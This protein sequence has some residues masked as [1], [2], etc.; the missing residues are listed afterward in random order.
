MSIDPNEARGGIGRRRR[1]PSAVPSLD[2]RVNNFIAE[3]IDVEQVGE[4]NLEDE[5]SVPSE[6]QERHQQRGREDRLRRRQEEADRRERGSRSG[7]ER[8]SYDA[9]PRSRSR[10][11]RRSNSTRPVQ[12][13]TDPAPPV[14]RNVP[15]PSPPPT[16][17]PPEKN[18]PRK[19]LVSKEE[20]RNLA[21]WLN[22]SVTPAELKGFSE[23]YPIEFEKKE[24]SLAPPR[25]DDW[26]AR[27]LK[28]S[29]AQKPAEAA[30]KTWLSV[31]IKVLD[32]AGPLVYLHQLTKQGRPL[33]MEDVSENVK[34]ALELTAAASYDI[35]RRRRRNILSHTNPRSDYLLEDPKSF[36]SKQTVSSLFGK[37]F[38]EAMLKEA[39][40]DEK[41]SRRGP[42]GPAPPKAASGPVTR[43]RSGRGGRW[44]AFFL[45][46]RSGGRGR[47][48]K[49][50]RLIIYLDDILIL[51]RSFSEALDHCAVVAETL[52]A[53]GFV[54]NEAKSVKQ[55]VQRIDYLG[56]VVDST[57]LSFAL[58]QEKMNHSLDNYHFANRICFRK[59]DFKYHV[60]AVGL[61]R[62]LHVYGNAPG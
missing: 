29:A 14:T 61:N 31:Q 36:S 54:I 10:S 11:P 16:T 27:R 55:P 7:K 33:D 20:S 21:D 32:I 53:L 40:H 5:V 22:K 41:L 28:E 39:D 18:H 47:R 3:L 37:R 59:F 8:R 24:F 49:G 19:I 30:E 23:K 44:Q 60:V 9:R 1:A 12:T 56:V 43:A 6:R 15:P 50:I 35:P 17:G 45:N 48:A 42:P 57:K 13:S 34:V 58:P 62:C 2:P 38:L 46:D 52:T 51:S 4:V 25:L 26:M